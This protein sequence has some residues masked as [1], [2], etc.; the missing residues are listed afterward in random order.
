VISGKEKIKVLVVDDH[1]VVRRGLQTCLSRQERLKIVGEAADGEEAV[2]KTRQ[3]KPDVLLLDIDL[4][5]M[6][7]LAVTELLRKEAPSV[8]ILALSVHT[9]RQ[10]LFRIIQAGAHGYVSKEASPEEL[11]HAIEAVWEGEPFFTPEVAQAALSELVSGGGKK[12]LAAKLSE[13]EREV[14]ALIAEGRSN[15]EVASRLGIG[16]RTI[17]THRERIMRKLDIHSIAGLTRFAIV[18]GL[19]SL[20]Q[21]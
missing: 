16:V 9:N 11:V 15:K 17:E 10:F 8:R 2:S 1:P 5:R 4:P 7:G 19:V 20:D 3:L 12:Q 13:R 14:L 18:N 6:N 21:T